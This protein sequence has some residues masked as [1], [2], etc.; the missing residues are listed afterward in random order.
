[1]SGVVARRPR[2]PTPGACPS[3]TPH[4]G[5][6]PLHSLPSRLCLAWRTRGADRR[7][8][9]SPEPRVPGRCRRF[10][11]RKPAR[12]SARRRPR[13]SSPAAPGGPRSHDGRR[14][15]EAPWCLS[16]VTCPFGRIVRTQSTDRPSPARP[17]EVFRVAT[18]MPPDAAVAAMQPSG[19]GTARSTRA[20]AIRSA[21]ACAAARSKARFLPRTLPHLSL[22]VLVQPVA[23]MSGRQRMHPEPRFLH[24]VLAERPSVSRACAPSHS[25]SRGAGGVRNGYDPAF[26][27]TRFIRDRSGRGPLRCRAR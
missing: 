26:V 2:F 3:I 8:I 10:E 5:S 15:R 27:S 24:P 7:R 12:R 18:V 16:P 17:P 9:P 20:R 25:A 14:G 19:T 1:M 13:P 6:S 11:G 4:S 22:Q 23:T 21:Q